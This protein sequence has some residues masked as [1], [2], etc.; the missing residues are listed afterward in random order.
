[1]ECLMVWLGVE[2]LQISLPL[3]DYDG[4]GKTDIAV[5][6][7]ENGYWYIIRSSGGNTTYTPWG[8]LNDILV[9]Q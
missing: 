5:W 7:P 4:K 9:S 1:M 3:G 6:R 2:M 8:A